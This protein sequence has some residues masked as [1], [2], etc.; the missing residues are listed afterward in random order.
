MN[1]IV[2]AKALFLHF[3][4]ILQLPKNLSGIVTD[5]HIIAWFTVIYE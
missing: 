1:H 2:E 5:V 4:G 3:V